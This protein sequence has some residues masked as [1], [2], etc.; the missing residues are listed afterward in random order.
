MQN[1]K[2]LKEH[3]DKMEHEVI[4]MRKIVIDKEKV[5]RIKTEQV[6]NDLMLASEEISLK[7]KAPSA[8]EEIRSQ[9]EK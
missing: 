5:N 2:N 8:V 1:L 4:Q 6:W 7:W 3:L 9:R